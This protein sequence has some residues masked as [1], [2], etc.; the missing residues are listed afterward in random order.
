MCAVRELTG[1]PYEIMGKRIVFTNW[2]FVYPG[3]FSW[4]DKEGYRLTLHDDLASDEGYFRGKDTP[5]GI[6]IIIQRPHKY[7]PL[8]T[9]ER[10]W[11]EGGINFGTILKEGDIYRAWAS[12]SW[13]DLKG[14]SHKYFCHFESKD[15]YHWDRPDYGLFSF[16][17]N[18]GSNILGRQGG[19]VFIDP[20][21]EP[22]QRYK[23][24]SEYH[25][26]REEYMRYALVHPDEIDP[27]SDRSSDAGLYLGILGAVSPDG[28]RWN[29][30]PDPI[31]MTHS[32]THVVA[33]YDPILKKYVT[34]F[35]DWA[36]GKQADGNWEKNGSPRWLTVGR[37]AIGRSESD[38]FEHF[39]LPTVILEPSPDMLPNDLFYTNCK[40]TIPDAP[41]HHLLFPAVWNTGRDDTRIEAY[42]SFDSLNWH[43]I[44]REPVLETG[45]FGEWDG[46]CIFAIPNMI[47]L[48]NGD[49]ALPYTGYNVPHK[50][51]R[52]RAL[53]ASGYAVWPKGRFVALEAKDI[54][55]FSTVAIIPPG[56]KLHVNVRTAR[57]GYLLVEVADLNGVPIPGRTFEDAVPI[58]GD[59]M[60]ASVV[61]IAHNDLG[62]APGQ[63]VRLRFRLRQASIYS[64]DFNEARE[65]Q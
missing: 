1:D 17:G 26:S 54:G 4:V 51:P 8:L 50:F 35:R 58:C 46:G 14:R 42:S 65:Q 36:V 30:L 37:R 11:E 25:Y 2:H 6:E 33:Y 48:P 22:D 60:S 5:I 29:I 38:H 28:L 27:R 43:R 40:T 19:S 21:C 56:S 13:G 18:S 7:G 15:G 57:S 31:V 62:V 9:P 12:T 49:Y 10:E 44:S 3:T 23:F 32:D 63:P 61:W 34:Y 45:P 59:H 20:S 16:D 52:R 24:V 55:E 39:P 41:D 53:R 64:L 47:E